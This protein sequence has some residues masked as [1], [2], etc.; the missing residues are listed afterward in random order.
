MAVASHPAARTRARARIRWDRVGRV[1]MLCA[2][3]LLLYLAVSP[4][5]AFISDVQ[6]SAQRQ[7][8][9]H[10]LQRQ[11]AVLA[12]QQRDLSLPST[13]QIQERN[14]GYVRPGERPYVLN[15]LPNN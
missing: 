13:A 9:L 2:L 1:A 8:Q 5:R 14:A 4:V 12:T 7:A 3:V 15:G 11:A 6:L 10:A